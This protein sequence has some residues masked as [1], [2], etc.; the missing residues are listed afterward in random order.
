MRGIVITLLVIL[1]IF[2]TASKFFVESTGISPK[3][4][5]TVH[6]SMLGS[7]DS[8][9]KS[10][11]IMDPIMLEERIGND[12]DLQEA[13]KGN[14]LFVSPDNPSVEGVVN[15]ELGYMRRGKPVLNSI[16]GTQPPKSGDW[17]IND[18]T[19]VEDCVLI[20]NGSIIVNDTG[21]LILR[22]SDIY[23]NLSY[24]GEH[25]IDV[26]GNLTVLGGLITACLL[27]TSPS[28]RDRG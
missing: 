11:I 27:Y 15:I 5:A 4:V 28:P 2:S 16:T 25:R 26:Y 21:A 17:T 8:Q 3:G 20:I 13:Q 6:T 19:V 9:E 22:N 10:H 18:T 1:T 7:K 24:D 23:M 14:M 12:W